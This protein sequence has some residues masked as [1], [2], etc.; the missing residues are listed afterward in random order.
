MRSLF[1][2][3]EEV[4]LRFV[5]APSLLALFDFDG[6]LALIVERPEGASLPASTKE[7]LTQLLSCPSLQI[8]VISG[9]A[10]ADVKDR[11]GLDG[12][13]YAGNHGLEIEGPGLCFVH[14]EAEAARPFLVEAKRRLTEIAT[15]FPGAI[16]E[17]KGLTLSF[18]VRPLPEDLR[19]KA[20]ARA[21]EVLAPFLASGHLWRTEGKLVLEIRPPVAWDKGSAVRL[22]MERSKIKGAYPLVF[23][24]GDDETDEVAF[25]AVG[26]EG[27]AIFVGLRHDTG[28]ARYVLDGPEEVERFLEQLLT[29]RG[30]HAKGRIGW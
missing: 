2:A 1:T 10:L 4:A 12:I 21:E 22:L 13:F 11:V 14:P 27:L 23:Y 26:E 28:K 6:T 25:A 24:V 3:W 5:S 18:H 15:D 7:L 8:G 16:L 19:A 30:P 9:R 29:L 17:D 20:K